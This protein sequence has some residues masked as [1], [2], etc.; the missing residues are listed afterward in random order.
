M[1]SFF[2]VVTSLNIP[3][4][5]QINRTSENVSDAVIKG[6]VKCRA[7]PSIIA[8]KQNCFSKPNFSFLV[9]E[10]VDIRKEIKMLQSN[11]A[12]QNTV[13]LTKLIKDN[14]AFFAKLVFVSLNKSIEQS[15]SH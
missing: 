3:Q 10:I 13:F 14:A 15:A 2:N 11:K 9:V 6:I 4:F 5:N 7:D 8:I 1:N 12:T